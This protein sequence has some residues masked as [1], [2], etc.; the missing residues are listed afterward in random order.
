[1]TCEAL[2]RHDVIVGFNLSGAGCR[3]AR[4]GTSKIRTAS[5]HECRLEPTLWF[6]RFTYSQEADSVFRPLISRAW[7]VLAAELEARDRTEPQDE[8]PDD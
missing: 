1:M 3:G 5:S 6:M 8:N 7:Q 4:S 2:T